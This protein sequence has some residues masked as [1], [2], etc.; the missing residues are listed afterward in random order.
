MSDRIRLVSEAEPVLGLG[1]R[2]PAAPHT[3]ASIG[4]LRCRL[5]SSDLCSIHDRWLIW[6]IL[7]PESC[8]LTVENQQLGSC[9][10]VTGE[11]LKLKVC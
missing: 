8:F 1:V 3:A 4:E 2:D 6:V 7:G 10:C 9:R 11:R 5:R